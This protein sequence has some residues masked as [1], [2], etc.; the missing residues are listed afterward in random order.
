MREK[1]VAAKGKADE[2]P[3]VYRDRHRSLWLR[4]LWVVKIVDSD[5]A[6]EKYKA[7]TLAA[8]AELPC[9][10]SFFEHQ[11][12]FAKFKAECETVGKPLSQNGEEIERS[13]AVEIIKARN[14]VVNKYEIV[15]RYALDAVKSSIGGFD[16]AFRAE[17]REK[18]ADDRETQTQSDRTG[19]LK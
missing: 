5:E 9:P 2:Q 4:S 12:S 7:D 18:A 10:K 15:L 8:P 17:E 19:F 1:E 3:S 14:E 13:N 11:V 6:F 16:S